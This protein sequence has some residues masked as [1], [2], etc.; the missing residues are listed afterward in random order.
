MKRDNTDKS[1]F[2]SNGSPA[3][4]KDASNASGVLD[5]LFSGDVLGHHVSWV[6]SAKH[7]QQL[8]ITS[9]HPLLHPQIRHRKVADFTKPFT[10][11]DAYCRSCIRMHSKV[12]REP[13][14]CSNTL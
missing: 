8:E 10:A 12:P 14:I 5:E 4:N 2:W 6:V 11:A 3:L 9:T 13:Q 7:F 1:E